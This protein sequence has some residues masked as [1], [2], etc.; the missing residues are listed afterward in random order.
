MLQSALSSYGGFARDWGQELA[1]ATPHLSQLLREARRPAR[2]ARG[3]G[4]AAAAAAGV[5][6]LLFRQAPSA[7]TDSAEDEILLEQVNAQISRTAPVA[8]DP[9]LIWMERNDSTGE[10]Q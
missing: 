5:L 2:L 8:L 9:L 3:T 7:P 10:K 6:V 4:L 1:P